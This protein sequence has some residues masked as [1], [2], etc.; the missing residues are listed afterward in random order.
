MVT[1]RQWLKTSVGVV[2]AGMAVDLT[3]ECPITPAN[4]RGPFY[5]DQAIPEL[6]DLTNGGKAR[7]E[8]IY[9][10][11]RILDVRCQGVAG[12][13]VEI[14][15]CDVNGRYKHARA[16]SQSLD[17]DFAY[18][19]KAT[20]D[21]RGGYFFK[22]MMPVT[23]GSAGFRRAPHIH[24]LV[25]KRGFRELAT[26]MQFAGAPFEKMRAVDSVFKSIPE[27]ERAAVIVPRK[28]TSAFPELSG[29]FDDEAPCC[30]FDL[31]LRFS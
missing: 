7:G 15:Q 20:S 11:G 27:Q 14:W 28:S 25:H 29:R 3:A 22:T 6:V 9:V 19:S 24:F 18:F 30:R 17:P 2:G 1:R 21:D 8:P 23:Y 12:A 4:G 31:V 26:E 13:E 16:R 10:F 5:P